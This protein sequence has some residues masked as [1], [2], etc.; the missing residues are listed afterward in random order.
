MKKRIGYTLFSQTKEK[1]VLLKTSKAF[2][3]KVS[4]AF[5][6]SGLRSMLGAWT[7][8]RKENCSLPMI[9]DTFSS[10]FKKILISNGLPEKLNVHRIRQSVACRKQL[11]SFRK[12]LGGLKY[13]SINNRIEFKWKLC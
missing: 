9:P 5:R 7:E 4:Y 10:R 6:Y 2:P 12:V 11:R 3:C 13:K 1:Y 8:K